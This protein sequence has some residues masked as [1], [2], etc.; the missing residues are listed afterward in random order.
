MYITG[1]PF[2]HRTFTGAR[3]APKRHQGYIYLYHRAQNWYQL[4]R[5]P[6]FDTILLLFLCHPFQPSPIP[7][8]RVV[9]FYQLSFWCY[10]IVLMSHWLAA[11]GSQC[12]PLQPLLWWGLNF[13]LNGIRRVILYPKNYSFDTIIS[14]Y[15][16]GRPLPPFPFTGARGAHKRQ[17]AYIYSYQRVQHSYQLFKKPWF[18]TPVVFYYFYMS[19]LPTLVH[20]VAKGISSRSVL[21]S[22]LL[23]YKKKLS[24]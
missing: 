6:W 20:I 19:P 1:R 11:F 2:P 10:K 13:A 7:L 4:F 5:K 23:N 24:L 22:M 16:T 8:L 18:D 21:L 12:H 14:D 3:G 17:Q 15:F 9:R